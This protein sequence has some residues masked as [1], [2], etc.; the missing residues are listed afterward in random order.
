MRTT[1]AAPVYVNWDLTYACPLRCIHCY[2]ESGR[3]PSHPFVVERLLPV[4]NNQDWAAAARDID[5]FFAT[6]EDRARI[7]RRTPAQPN[8]QQER[9]HDLAMHPVAASV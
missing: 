3:R 1:P 9:R 4:L 7:S 2:S 5:R 8:A 6:P